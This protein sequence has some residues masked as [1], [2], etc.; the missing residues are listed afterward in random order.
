MIG[1]A[2]ETP[3]PPPLPA[4]ISPSTFLPLVDVKYS[5]IYDMLYTITL[6][7][8][9]SNSMYAVIW[10]QQFFSTRSIW[11]THFEAGTC[12]RQDINSCEL[13]LEGLHCPITLVSHHNGFPFVNFIYS[14]ILTF[15]YYNN[16]SEGYQCLNWRVG[17]AFLGFIRLPEDG[18]SVPKHVAVDT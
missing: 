6:Y 13:V 7:S 8:L 9:N 3:P 15:E 17:L 4:S 1:L 11:I 18:S 10:N 14:R 12:L 2:F 5:D 16:S